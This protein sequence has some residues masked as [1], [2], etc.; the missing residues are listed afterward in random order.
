[1][2]GAR[3]MINSFLRGLSAGAIGK[4]VDPVIDALSNKRRHDIGLQI[5]EAKN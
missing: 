4:D 5:G 2:S 1:M 3:A